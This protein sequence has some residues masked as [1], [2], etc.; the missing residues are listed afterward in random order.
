MAQR[1]GLISDTHGWLDPRVLDE[2]AGVDAILHAG[3]V[4]A[5]VIVDTLR[6]LA[7]TYV[8]R[9]NNDRT[10]DLLALPEHIDL[11]MSGTRIH[12][13]HRPQDARPSDAGIV[14]YGHTHRARVERRGDVWWVNPGAA[15]RRGFHTER[16]IAAMELG[17]GP[18]R[19][20][21]ISLGPRAAPRARN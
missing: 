9:G 3:D 4:G 21:V 1:V 8:V 18:P 12:V 16:T 10:P 2:L 19:V 20:R 14:V 11:E 6:R 17:D 13:V 15:G 5:L 7:P